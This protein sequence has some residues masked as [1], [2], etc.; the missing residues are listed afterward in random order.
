MFI[1]LLM[2]LTN[3]LVGMSL[4]N[5]NYVAS[6]LLLDWFDYRPL[7]SC[8]IGI[9]LIKVIQP[10]RPERC[11]REFRPSSYR[12]P[13][14]QLFLTCEDMEIAQKGQRRKNAQG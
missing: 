1:T 14:D 4:T 2:I 9:A 12:G 10:I 8:S 11:A 6:A 5:L 13:G 7:S 3:G